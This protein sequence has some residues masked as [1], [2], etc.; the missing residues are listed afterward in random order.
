MTPPREPGSTVRQLP[1]T[2]D[3]RS[4]SRDVSAVRQASRLEWGWGEERS[5]P[6]RPS[7][8][9]TLTSLTGTFPVSMLAVDLVLGVQGSDFWCYVRGKEV[10]LVAVIVVEGMS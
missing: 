10:V 1:V 4:G 9:V 3:Q 6:V 2:L 7:T 8:L 5:G